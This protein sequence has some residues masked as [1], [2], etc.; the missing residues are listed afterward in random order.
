MASVCST[1]VTKSNSG[2][3][4]FL[5]VTT[6]EKNFTL[7]IKSQSVLLISLISFHNVIA[8][9]LLKLPLDEVIML[10][11]LEMQTCLSKEK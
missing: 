1:L 8:G 9:I 6:L 2:S 7:M 11:V 5:P 4:V 3:S 10:E